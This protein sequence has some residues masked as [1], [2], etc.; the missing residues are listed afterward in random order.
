MGRVS[1]VWGRVWRNGE[2]QDD[3]EFSRISDC[4]VEPGTLVWADV[5]ASDHAILKELAHELGLNEWAVEDAVAEAERT[6][7]TVYATHTFFT[8]YS[9]DT[10]VPESDTESALAIHRI[11]A[12]VL[13]QGLITVRLSSDFDIDAVSARFDEL[14]G[15]EFGVGA[16]VHALLDTVVD[17]HFTAVQY[18]DDAIEEIEDALFSDSMPRGGLQRTTFQLRKDLVHLR[19]V[20]L[21]MREVVN[22]IQHRRLDARMSPELD[23]RYADLYDHVLRASEWTESLRDMITTVFET[24]L[25][26]QDARLNMVMKKLTGW[27]AIIAV[28]TAITGFYGQ[29][30]MYPGI[31]T[32]G[33]FLT[34]SAIIVLLVAI[35]YVM[36]KR[37]DWL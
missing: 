20:V 26:L 23:P 16:L 11:S 33:G 8:V 9:V 28:P 6:K 12:F 4:L 30:V 22:S 35:L 27:A 32:V 24:N 2:P 7:A 17:S 37:R 25:S 15:Q 29:N 19:R 14:G 5:Y 36:F 31:E 18:L 21:P 34:S 3:F 1:D 13:P 10:Q